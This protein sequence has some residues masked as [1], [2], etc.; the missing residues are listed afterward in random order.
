[1]AGLGTDAKE[2]R[3]AT[4]IAQEVKR[5]NGD[6]PRC[7]TPSTAD[8]EENPKESSKACE[9]DSYEEIPTNADSDEEDAVSWL[10]KALAGYT[11]KGSR[12]DM[13]IFEPR[14]GT[15]C[16][17]CTCVTGG[18]RI[19]EAVYDWDANVLWWGFE[20]KSHSWF[21]MDPNELSQKPEQVSWYAAKDLNAEQWNPRFKWRREHGENFGKN[22]AFRKP[23]QSSFSDGLPRWQPKA[24]KA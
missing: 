21:F 4:T 5:E 2:V 11:W 16:W 20:G 23:V 14:D 18:T 15:S 22:Q 19:S 7:E 10:Q 24:G 17:T 8:S 1:V 12:G 9:G 3:D 6:F 13:Y